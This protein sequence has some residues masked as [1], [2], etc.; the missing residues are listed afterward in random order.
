MKYDR[1]LQDILKDCLVV[2]IETSSID[3]RG[4][5]INIKK[6]SQK[7]V[8]NAKIKFFGAYSYRENKTYLLNYQT[9]AEKI[10]ELLDTHKILVSFNG[11]EFDFPIM[12]NNG[13]VNPDKSYINVDC[14]VILGKPNFRT[15]DGYAYKDKGTLMRFNLKKRSLR[16]MAK[17]M[18]VETQKGNIDYKIFYKNSW[19]E[20]ETQ[21]I[22]KYL[23]DDILATKQI[24]DKLWEFWKPFTEMLNV[25]EI[26]NLSW[27]RSSIASLIYKSVCSLLNLKPTYS[28]TKGKLEEMGGRVIEPK[29]EEVKNVWYV[30]YTSL[31]PH[32]MT[33]FNLFSETNYKGISTVW[34][35]N[36][37]FK[38]RGSYD[39]SRP[40]QL[41]EIIKQKLKQR[42]EL[43]KN[44]PD[45]PM[46]YTLKIFLNGLYG[47][48][49]SSIFEQ[50]HTP[51]AG[52]DTCWLGQQIHKLT[53]KMLDDFGFEIVYGDTD[54]AMLVAKEEKYNDRKYL[55]ECLD[56]IVNKINDNVPF[57]VDTFD[58]NIEAFLRYVMFPFSF[59]PIQDKDGNNIK[60][61]NRLVKKR[62]GR[63]KNY[64]YIT[65]EDGANVV[66]IK[67]LPIIKDNATALGIKIYQEVLEPMIL[68]DKK[69]KFSEDFIKKTLDSY[70]KDPEIMKFVAREFKVKPFETYKT[71]SQIQAQISQGYFNGNEGVI[72][73]IKNKKIGKAGIATKYCTID[74][75][76]EN[77]LTTDD[78]DLT[79]LFNELEPFVKYKE[80]IK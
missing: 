65:E 66:K 52:W 32:I 72:N 78:L 21:E 43:K 68:K 20:N 62:K 49:R 50:V 64:L 80:K 23:K 12:Q 47:V 14:M 58:I 6:N 35:G 53:E 71:P 16:Y 70:L 28:D 7:Y 55:R 26:R 24:F 38:T 48:I 4:N 11:M 30:D 56:K 33:M 18:G 60:E 41:A 19:N 57:P 13:I 79:K 15:K 29:Y 76:I 45:N 51:N 37:I 36:D 8:D 17:E 39:I 25:S 1:L 74:E 27:I 22:K 42:I 3:H 31:Y 63:K 44:D 69:A 2:D 75:A 73:L 5:L 77:N 34:N 54:S 9:E 10:N 59:Q 40:H 46:I 61:K 67:G